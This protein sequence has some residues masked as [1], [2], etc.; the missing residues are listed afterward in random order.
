MRKK[1][2]FHYLQFLLVSCSLCFTNF[3]SSAHDGGTLSLENGG[4]VFC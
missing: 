4:G 3:P 1:I 2:D